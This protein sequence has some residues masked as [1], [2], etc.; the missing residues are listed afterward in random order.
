M[1]TERECNGKRTGDTAICCSLSLVKALW[2]KSLCHCWGRGGWGEGSERQR[3][4]RRERKRQCQGLIAPVGVMVRQLSWRVGGGGHR[5]TLFLLLFLC[6]FLQKTLYRL[7]L[8]LFALPSS[9][10]EPIPWRLQW[11]LSE[12]TRA[13]VLLVKWQ[14][15]RLKDRTGQ[16]QWEDEQEKVRSGLGSKFSVDPEV[17]VFCKCVLTVISRAWMLSSP[18]QRKGPDSGLEGSRN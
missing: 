11:L 3:K 17:C 6:M 9:C 13:A 18:R 15:W 5:S 8:L 4:I 1:E 16:G 2:L 7:V 14:R 10:C 12:S